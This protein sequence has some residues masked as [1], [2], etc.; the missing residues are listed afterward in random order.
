MPVTF[1]FKQNKTLE[2][3]SSEITFERAKTQTEAYTNGTNIILVDDGHGNKAPLKSF[4]FDVDHIKKLAM[5]PGTT[6]IQLMI[7]VSPA[8]QNN[9]TIIAGA[10]IDNGIVGCT[11]NESLLYDFCEPC[12]S[13]C[14]INI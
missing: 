9:L 7:A 12:P 8:N 14:S 5:L 11:V 4:R 2:M 10:V 3:D 13:K 1:E 6:H